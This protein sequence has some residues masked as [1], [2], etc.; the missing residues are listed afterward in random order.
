[1][2]KWTGWDL[3]PRPLPCQDSDLPA[4]LPAQQASSKCERD[5]N[6]RSSRA[7]GMRSPGDQQ[8]AEK[9]LLGSVAGRSDLH[10]RFSLRRA[11]EPFKLLDAAELLAGNLDRIHA[12]QA[13]EAKVLPGMAERADQARHAEVPE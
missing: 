1:M 11:R 7:V 5:K 2:G 6:A 9:I 13:A 10:F 8:A 4:D 3:N 12:R